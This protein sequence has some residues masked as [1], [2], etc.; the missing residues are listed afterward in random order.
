MELL[1]F[2][3]QTTWFYFGCAGLGLSVLLG[4]YAWRMGFLRRKQRQMQATQERLEIDVQHRTAELT[5]ANASLSVENAERSQ[6]EALLSRSR[7]EFKDLFDNAPVGFH[8]IDAEG[9]LVRVN[10]TEL[11]MLGYTAGELMG[12]FVWKISAEEEP[13]RRTA[14]AI[15]GGELPASEGFERVFRRK[16]GSI[17]PVMVTGCWGG[18]MAPSPAF[19]QRCRTSPSASRRS[20]AATGTQP[21]AHAD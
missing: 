7:E 15:M 4:I 11:K 12:Q 17:F 13:S 14:R 21:V 9:R 6:S 16:D 10:N 1:P 19:A 20:G 5:R 8:E 2:F 3:Y 18:R